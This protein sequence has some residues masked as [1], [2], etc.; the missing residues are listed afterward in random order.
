MKLFDKSELELA[1]L[2][3]IEMLKEE[4]ITSLF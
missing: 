3:M 2:R 1:C 4:K